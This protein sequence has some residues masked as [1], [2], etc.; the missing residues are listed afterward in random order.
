MSSYKVDL[1]IAALASRQHGVFSR[2]QAFT[3]GASSSFIDR[4]L[5]SGLWI[6]LDERIYALPGNPPT[7]LRQAKAAELGSALAVVTGKSAGVLHRIDGLKPGRPEVTMPHGTHY[8][9][10]LATVRRRRNPIPT[11]QVQGV[12]T[13]TLPRTFLDIAGWL[14]PRQLGYRLD[15]AKLARRLELEDVAEQMVGSRFSHP[16]EMRR[17]AP[18]LARRLH[19]HEPAESVLELELHRVLAQAR[20][21][22]LVHQAPPP[23]W[24][25]GRLRVDVLV[26]A[27]RLIIEADGRPYHARM[28]DFERDR[29]R[30]NQSTIHGWGVLRYTWRRLTTARAQVV[31][32]LEALCHEPLVRS[33]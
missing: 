10:R 24:P 13:T 6:R 8:A 9:S 30:D 21:P 22:G 2:R 12:T 14:S 29:W 28:A 32:E 26:P 16:Y 3:A 5:R 20:V 33:A 7:W 11:M 25:E 4:R 1:V 31:A 19:E 27:A 17:L 15:E 23:W 18:V